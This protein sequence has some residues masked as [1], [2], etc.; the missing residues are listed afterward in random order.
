MTSSNPDDRKAQRRT[1]SRLG[2]TD[3]PALRL[4]M[5]APLLGGVLLVV[6]AFVLAQILGRTLVEGELLAS[7]WPLVGLA[8]ALM[9]IR[10]GITAAG[11]RWGIQAAEAIKQMLRL[12]LF[13]DLMAKPLDFTASRSSG[14]LAA[15]AL[16]QVEALDGYFARYLPAMVAASVLP[17]AFSAVVMPVDWVAGLLFLLTAPL[18]PVFM[19]LAGWGAEA[20]T[21]AQ[22]G[23]LTRLSGRFADRLRG[24]LTLK[25]MGRAEAETHAIVEASEE[26]RRRT[27]SVLRIAFLSSAV[28]EFFAALGVAGIALYV[29]LTFIGYLTVNPELSLAGGLFLLLMAPEVYQPL[30]VLAAHYH[31]RAAALAALG[32]IER[33]FE[34]VPEGET[35]RP[36][37]STARTTAPHKAIGFAVSGL[38]LTT[39]DGRVPLLL[40]TSVEIAPGEHVALLGTSG[41]GKSTLLETLARLRPANGTILLGDRLLASLPEAQLRAEL[42]LLGQRPRLFAGTIAQN[43]RLGRPDAGER[44]VEAAALRAC[45]TDFAGLL[46]N[47]LDARIGE[48]GLGL[49]AGEASRVALARLY[50][51]DPSVVLLDEPTAHLDSVTERRVIEGLV[52]FCTGRTLLVATHSPILA[53]AM[54]RS[55]RLAGERLLPSIAPVRAVA[56][57]R[58]ERA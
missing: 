17:L 46:P 48:G 1:L 21:K 56:E 54:Q 42:A 24:I 33:Q 40:D 7:L 45:V 32:E 15:T 41:S 55:L 28:L 39:P 34:A 30:R 36:A 25:L 22:A 5:A 38:R 3:G 10:A 2:H 37:T 53:G 8:L 51:L 26:L 31:D 20:A 29:G 47:W 19:A 43:I 13:D 12:S 52:D 4:A 49:S 44:E 27:L 35:I 16:E 58:R 50:L 14:A 6:Q 9:L 23:A 18:I 11:E 57:P